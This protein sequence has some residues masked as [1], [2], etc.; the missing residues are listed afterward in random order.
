MNTPISQSVQP[1]RSEPAP[2]RLRRFASMMYEGVLLFGVVFLAG[3]AFDTLTQSRHGLALRHTRQALLFL[4]IGFYFIL[5]WRRSGQTLPMKAW[6]IRLVSTTGGQL[7]MRQ[8][9]VRYACMWVFP[10]AGAFA[11]WV[12]AEWTAWP[13]VLM[14]IVAAPFTVFIP[15]L[16]ATNQQFW[17]DKMAGTL[18]VSTPVNKK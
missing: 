17:H 6:N 8:M 18:L 15:T 2:A 3:Y 10:A 16:Y 9:L 12:L 13:S 7:T 1:P 11:V 5:C 4:A 14:L